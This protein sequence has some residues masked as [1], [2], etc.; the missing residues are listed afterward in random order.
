MK[1]LRIAAL[2]A[3]VV[4]SG[5]LKPAGTGS[6]NSAAPS[7]AAA[8]SNAAPAT[9]LAAA[10]PPL[11]PPAPTEGPITAAD[12]PIVRAGYWSQTATAEGG[13]AQTTYKCQL[14]GQRLMAMPQI[15][16]TC[17][18]PVFKRT[19]AGAITVDLVCTT[20]QGAMS[21]HTTVQGDYNSAYSG[22]SVITVSR[23]GQPDRVVRGHSEVRY[24]GDCPAGAATPAPPSDTGG[25]DRGDGGD[26]APSQGGKQF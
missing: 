15:P 25:G 9:N 4:A 11:A 17:M 1:V 20:N 12:M 14:P 7:N 3:L 13:Q 23:P 18:A 22:D 6:S 2:A 16:P 5:C 8:G 26:R 21:T 24:L 10:P 19:A